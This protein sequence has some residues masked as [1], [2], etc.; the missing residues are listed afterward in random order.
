MFVDMAPPTFSNCP[1]DMIYID[2]TMPVYFTVPMATDN[3]GGIRNVSVMPANFRN[4]TVVSQDMEVVYRAEDFS[5]NVGNCTLKIRIK[6]K[7]KRKRS[8]SVL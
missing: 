1:T 7:R 8:D 6:G 4:G 5:G 3:S 2:M